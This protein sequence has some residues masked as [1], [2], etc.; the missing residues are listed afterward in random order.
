[1][2]DNLWNGQRT[3]LAEKRKTSLYFLW[4]PRFELAESRVP[5]VF[6]RIP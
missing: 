2:F 1:M 3:L 4:L 6:R 5:K